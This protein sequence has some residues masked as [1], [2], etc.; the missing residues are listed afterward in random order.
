MKK[1][2]HSGKGLLILFVILLCAYLYLDQRYVRP[3]I[4]PLI[5]GTVTHDVGAYYEQL[6]MRKG[7]IGTYEVSPPTGDPMETQVFY[8]TLLTENGW[9]LKE[10]EVFEYGHHWHRA[11][12]SSGWV[13][14]YRFYNLLPESANYPDVS[15]DLNWVKR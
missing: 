5:E 4:I 15:Y 3:G 2:F 11:D 9:M 8:E 1:I 6:G 13:L 7:V 14:N 12:H 10:T